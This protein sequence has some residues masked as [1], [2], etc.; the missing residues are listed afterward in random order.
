M[1]NIS[2][3]IF[4]AIHEGKWL[5]I[6]YKN[7]DDNITK[8]WIGIK[9]IDMKHKSLV[10]EGLHLSKYS[11]CQLS[12]YIDSIIS[13]A[14]IPGSYFKINEELVENIKENPEKYQSLFGHIPNLR[15]LNYLSDCNR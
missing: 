10:V 3:D 6:E 2:K 7:K 12:I 14:V 4:K 1:K 9:S 15:I 8:Y 13:S 5:S 11:L